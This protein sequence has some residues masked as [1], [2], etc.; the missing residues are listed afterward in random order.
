V[1]CDS[2]WRDD[3]LEYEFCVAA[4]TPERE[5]VLTAQD[6]AGGGLD[7][8]DF[9]VRHGASLGGAPAE[10][11]ARRMTH[12]IVPAPVTFPDMPASRW[13]EF[14]NAGVDVSALE[15]GPEDPI[16]LLLVEFALIYGNDWF[17]MPVEMPVGSLSRV[18]SLVVTN[19]FGE[20]V[21]I[22]PFGRAG[23]AGTSW[24]MFAVTEEGRPPTPPPEG[25]PLFFLPPVLG[26]SVN[27]GALEEVAFLREEPA[28][29]VWG[30]EKLIESE[31]V[32]PSQPPEVVDVTEGTAYRYRLS[33]S[34][35]EFWIPFVPVA[36]ER[37]SMWLR[38]ARAL[39]THGNPVAPAGT[40]LGGGAPVLIHDE[41]VPREGINVRR[42]FQLARWT[43]GSSHLWTTR[44][45]QPVTREG[46]SG[47]RFD[48]AR[49]L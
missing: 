45:K 31:P 41:E 24:R 49:P 6:Y 3:R 11:R 18:R 17:L 27:G 46:S 32:R 1:R 2:A 43:D 33:T 37:G 38:R 16:R 13:W 9:T 39:D 4:A 7:W 19:S 8:F 28:N 20:K 23:G 47:R 48:V 12:A 44:Q 26:P 10:S 14:E 25:G 42:A 21:T 35:R 30:V 36:R 15:A 5:I 40:L 29:L 34:V 22:E